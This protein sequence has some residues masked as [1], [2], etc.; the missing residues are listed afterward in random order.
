MAKYLVYRNFVKVSTGYGEQTL[1]KEII[2]FVSNFLHWSVEGSISPKEWHFAFIGVFSQAVRYYHNLYT[3]SKHLNK[4]AYFSHLHTTG[5]KQHCVRD[6][7]SVWEILQNELRVKGHQCFETVLNSL[8]VCLKHWE[9]LG[10]NVATCTT[11]MFTLNVSGM[12]VRDE[13]ES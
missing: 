13:C 12:R 6:S 2:F 3:K 9:I 11:D 8:R 4:I 7:L 1:C 10:D 5:K